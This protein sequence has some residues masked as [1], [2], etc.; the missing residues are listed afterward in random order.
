MVTLLK[1]LFVRVMLIGFLGIAS[2]V[3]AVEPP[4]YDDPTDLWWC[5][6]CHTL[7]GV[8]TNLKTSPGNSDLCLSCHDEDPL[9]RAYKKHLR[10]TEMAVPGASGRNHRWDSGPSGYVTTNTPGGSTGSVISGIVHT[11]STNWDSTNDD[12]MKTNLKSLTFNGSVP[13]T[14]TITA[15]QEGEVGTATFNWTWQDEGSASA[16]TGGTGVTTNTNIALVTANVDST[17]DN[18]KISFING[19]TQSTT[20]N[21]SFCVGDS[22]TITVRPQINYPTTFSLTDSYANLTKKMLPHKN[23]PKDLPD[24]DGSAYIFQGSTYGKASCSTCHNQHYQSKKSF[25]PLSPAYTGSGTGEGRHF[26]RIDNEQNQL[27]LDCHSARNIGNDFAEPNTNPDDDVRTYSGTTKSHPVGVDFPSIKSQHVGLMH[28]APKEPSTSP[29][30]PSADQ[31]D[32]ATIGKASSDSNNTC[33]TDT[34]K[35]F[36]NTS[37]NYYAPTG[38][39]VYFVRQRVLTTAIASYSAN[40]VCWTVDAVSILAGDVYVIDTDGNPSNNFRLY[41]SVSQ[42]PTYTT[43]KVYCLTCHG[44]HWADSNELTYDAP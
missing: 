42:K 28:S 27:C 13:R 33:V 4:H 7:S 35:D 36:T 24:V 38:L 12:T 34:S 17:D 23:A 5:T 11:I 18:I 8:G 16:T 30:N 43:G 2:S 3:Y 32:K 39:H 21:K 37:N 25:D 29:A 15:A 40:Q 44:P 6:N 19:S 20:C 41:D 10:E 14:Y 1:K 9:A 26:Q 31:S 22:W